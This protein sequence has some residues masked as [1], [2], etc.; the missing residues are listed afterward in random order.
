M[1]KFIFAIATTLF[2]QAEANAYI[3]NLQLPTRR[4]IQLNVSPVLN[5]RTQFQARPEGSILVLQPTTDFG[6][7]SVPIGVDDN[8][9]YNSNSVARGICHAV[10][11]N[12]FVNYE[13]GDEESDMLD[14]EID[15]D[16]NHFNPGNYYSN[17][18]RRTGVKY[19]KA[20]LDEQSALIDV[21]ESNSYF[22]WVI[23]K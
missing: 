11:R 9:R 8:R 6:D 5:R 4:V 15:W 22:K 13:T 23:C 7:R 18:Y 3:V 14:K 21:L 12:S 19:N 10:H 16:R 20:I 2:L 1:Y 17:P